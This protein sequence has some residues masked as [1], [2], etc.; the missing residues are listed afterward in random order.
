MRIHMLKYPCLVLDHDDTVVQTMKTMSY[1]YF[2]Y[3]LSIFRP[4]E[5]ISFTDY[6]R[7]CH[8]YGFVE[9][10]RKRYGYTDQ[11]LTQEHDMWMEYVLSHTPDP[12]PGISDVLRRQKEEGG[13]ICVVS[14]SREDNILRDY[15]AHFG[16]D[17]DAIYGF[18]RPEEQRKPNPY[19]L[20]DIMKRFGL[21]A[22]EILVVDD[23]KLSCKM[24]APLGIRVAYA[25]WN[26]LDV[27]E[28]DEEMASICDFHFKTVSAFEEFLFG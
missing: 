6:V 28:V 25:G 27:P 24:A 3:G 14:H 1:P 20:Q 5:D 22:D 19:P 12:Y 17:P 15:R 16:F 18:E 23:M 10:C 26:G 21:S 7:D 13:L 4:G 2:L 8:H 11:E 9:L